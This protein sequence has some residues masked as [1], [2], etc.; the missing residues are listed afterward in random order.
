MLDKAITEILKEMPDWFYPLAAIIILM[1]LGFV[2]WWIF[3]GA[4]RY[5]DALVRE[6]RVITLQDEI[7]KEKEKSK[8][9]LGLSSQLKVCLE[10]VQAHIYSLNEFRSNTDEEIIKSTHHFVERVIDSLVSDVKFDP[11]ERHRCA[12][13]FEEEGEL[14]ILCGSSGFSQ[15][16]IENR[17]LDTNRSVAG[18]CFR[19]KEII[20]RDN[21]LDDE[22]W[23]KNPNSTSKYSALICIPT[24]AWGVLTIDA[25]S[26]MRE[27]V[28][29]IGQ[30]YGK[31]I[32]GII[33]EYTNS[34]ARHVESNA[35]E[36]EAAASGV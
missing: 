35:P 4:K 31:I 6:N 32:E 34:I 29:I 19:K 24:G 33:N 12:L 28:I 22:D 13:W 15:S 10:N 25:L 27:E 7:A 3:I 9:S 2:A 16:Y 8:I 23:E 26:P 30:L 5:S 36:D 18:K 1:C 20:K 14:F 21:V 17:R 11:G